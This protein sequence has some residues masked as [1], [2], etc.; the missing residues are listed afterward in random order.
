MIAPALDDERLPTNL[1]ER[2]SR[3]QAGDEVE[4]L[5]SRRGRMRRATLILGSRPAD[6]WQLE[7]DPSANV[8]QRRALDAWLPPR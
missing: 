1:D 3:L 4:V 8:S 2:L 6:A 5:L 7:V